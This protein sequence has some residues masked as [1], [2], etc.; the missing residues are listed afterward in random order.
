MTGQ[1]RA[2]REKSL[3]YKKGGYNEQLIVVEAY[4]KRTKGTKVV[5][6]GRK[7]G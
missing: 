6:K 1:R 5:N 7:R 2:P 4:M 3:E